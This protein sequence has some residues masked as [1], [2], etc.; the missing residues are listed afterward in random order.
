[1]TARDPDPP[2]AVNVLLVDDRAENRLALR[3]IL[4]DADYTIVEAGSASEALKHLLETEFAALLIDVVMPEMSGLELASLVR[5]RGRN[6]TVPIV[7]MSAVA[8]DL[9]AIYRA[10]TTGAVDYLIKPLIPEMVRAKVAV[11]AELFRQRK[12][13][14]A[15]SEARYRNLAEAVPHMVWTAHADGSVRYMNARWGELTGEHYAGGWLDRLHADDRPRYTELW[16]RAVQGGSDFQIECRI[17]TSGGSYRWHLCRAVPERDSQGRVIGWIGTF[18]DVD[19]QKRIQAALAAAIHARDEF[20][21]IAS[22]E[23]RTPITSLQLQVESLLAEAEKRRAPGESERWTRRMT[24]AAR[25]VERLTRLVEE[26]LDV[27]RLSMGKLR[28]EREEGDL[29]T[30]V[31]EVTGRFQEQADR[32]GCRLVVDAR[33]PVFGSWDRLRLEQV[34]TN[35]LS[36]AIKFGAGKPIEVSVRGGRPDPAMLVVRDHGIGIQQDDL[37]R[38][39]GRFE[40]AVSSRSYGGLGLGL[41]IVQQ[42]ASRHGGTV[43]ADSSPGAGAEFRVEL[44]CDQRDE[45]RPPTDPMLVAAN[46]AMAALSGGTPYSCAAPQPGIDNSAE[47]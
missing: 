47:R 15:Q 41:Y 19:D 40:R 45:R 16:Q 31:R 14:E 39:F 35:L 23:L 2:V 25:Q 43:S 36:N 3:A 9:N 38:I 12:Q 21:S 10:Y 6:A 26:L 28:L 4:G 24:M 34:M 44:P 11:F 29:A 18:T 46:D 33:G 17:E 32:V 22:H 5:T 8:T 1:M 13:L 42:I 27:S 30:I 20:L 37:E 7:F